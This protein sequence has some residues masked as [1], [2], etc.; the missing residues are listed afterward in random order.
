MQVDDN[1]LKEL[2]HDVEFL[3][4]HMSEEIDFSKASLLDLK[5]IKDR[6]DDLIVESNKE[7][8]V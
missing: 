3:I 4:G 8:S 6:L 5:G 2:Y 7:K 1:K